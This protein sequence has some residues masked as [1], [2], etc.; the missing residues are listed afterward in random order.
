MEG[1]LYSE[2]LKI[3]LTILLIAVALKSSACDLCAVYS[4]MEAKDARP[5]W[6]AGVSEQFTRFATLQEGGERVGDPVGQ[7]LD[8]SIT[9]FVLGYQFNGRFG[10]Q[11]NVP[12][13][14]RAFKRP[15]GF[16]VDRGTE[17]GFGDVSLIGRVR[18]FDWEQEDT[19][20]LVNALAGVKFPAGNSDRL[21]EE[22]NEVEVPGAPESGVHGH[23][24]ALGSGS[25]DGI[26]GAAVFARWKRAF[27]SAST[28]YAIRSEGDFDYRYANDLLWSGG[29]GALLVMSHRGTLSVQ[30]NVSGEWKTKDTLAGSKA[31]DTGITAVYL[32]PVISV[33]W[34]DRLSAE[35]DVDLPVIQDNTALQLVPDYRLRAGATWRF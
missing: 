32:G 26:V 10:L 34:H 22:L 4:A 30:F 6:S 13:I 29:P 9:Q 15:E 21:K 25:Y 11:V 1:A 12:V 19:T 2:S 31:Q 16:A 28:Q 20:L 24:L 27:A 7:R 14:Y 8:S 3:S 35:L 23:D 5:G 17:S 18:L 33:T